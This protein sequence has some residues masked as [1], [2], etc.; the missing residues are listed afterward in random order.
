VQSIDAICDADILMVQ[1]VF[2]DSVAAYVWP[3]LIDAMMVDPSL[4]ETF[5]LNPPTRDAFFLHF[6]SATLQPELRLVF[7]Y[8]FPSATVLYRKVKVSLP[9]NEEVNM[10]LAHAKYVHIVGGDPQKALARTRRR[11]LAN[12]PLC[13]LDVGAYM[14]SELSSLNQRLAQEQVRSSSPFLSIIC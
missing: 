5:L 1:I 13:V 6:P 7:Y 4:A 8:Y 3:Y 14:K 11:I 2:F 10:M 9:N 12:Q